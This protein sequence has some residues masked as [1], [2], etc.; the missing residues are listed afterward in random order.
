M[1]RTKWSPSHLIVPRYACLTRISRVTV[2][3]IFCSVSMISSPNGTVSPTHRD[4]AGEEDQTEKTESRLSRL[5]LQKAE[6][7]SDPCLTT[8]II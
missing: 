2:R 8:G 1:G 4:Q 6:S 3:V 7:P 5:L